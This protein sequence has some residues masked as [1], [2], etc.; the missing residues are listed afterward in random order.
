MG[1]GAVVAPA[2][3]AGMQVRTGTP[4]STETAAAAA[5][6]AAHRLRKEFGQAAC[7]I[8]VLGGTEFHA[9]DSEA[10]VKA[11]APELD[12]AMGPKAKFVT[13][14]MV[15]V[16]QTFAEHCGDGSR[17]WNLLPVGQSS[18]Y[19][20]GTDIN[21]GADLEERKAIF[22]EIG[23]IY[24]T[25]EG[26]P[27]VSQEARVAHTRGAAVVPLRRTGGASDGMFGFPPGALQEPPFATEGQWS[28]LASKTASVDESAAALVAI[29]QACANELAAASATIVRAPTPSRP[30]LLGRVSQLSAPMPK[31]GAEKKAIHAC[32]GAQEGEA[33][34]GG[35]Q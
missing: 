18:S 5:A 19:A 26:G 34:T 4:P 6:A 32:S 7:I 22:A 35:Q 25:V 31:P 8:C 10:L 23:D 2:R 15:G 33:L 27:G 14:G 12:A 9:A 16:Q 1:N 30:A 29:V 20:R 13:G 28:L 24:I 3:L 11:I 21:A 17:V